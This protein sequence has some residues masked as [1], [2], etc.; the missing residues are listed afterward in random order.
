MFTPTVTIPV[1]LKSDQH[2]ATFRQLRSEFSRINE[3]DIEEIE[4]QVEKTEDNNDVAFTLFLLEEQ[5]CYRPKIES[6]IRA[7]KRL[8]QVIVDVC[9]M[10]HLVQLFGWETS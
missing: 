5:A 9:K 2:R 8:D 7:Y 10:K 1:W 6:L 4:E 3:K